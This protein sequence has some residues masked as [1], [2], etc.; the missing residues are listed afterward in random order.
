MKMKQYRTRVVYT[1]TREDVEKSTLRQAKEDFGCIEDE[2]GEWLYG[3]TGKS[4]TIEARLEIYDED[5]K[6]W[7]EVKT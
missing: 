4:E 5:N 7:M 3:G 2:T 1:V 6:R